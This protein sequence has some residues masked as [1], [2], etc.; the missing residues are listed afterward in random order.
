MKKLIFLCMILSIGCVSIPPVYKAKNDSNEEVVISVLHYIENNFFDP[1]SANRLA[2][3]Q[4]ENRGSFKLVCFEVNARN[5]LGG[6]TGG[7]ESLGIYPEHS[8]KIMKDG[9]VRQGRIGLNTYPCNRSQYWNKEVPVIY[10]KR[11]NIFDYP[12]YQSK[13]DS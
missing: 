5:R 9:S 12:G 1:D 3:Y 13:W 6:Y 7:G 11:D 4:P 2:I 10:Q 8:I